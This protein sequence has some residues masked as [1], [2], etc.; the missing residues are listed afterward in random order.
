MEIALQIS[1]INISGQRRIHVEK[2]ILDTNNI[3]GLMCGLVL[4]VHVWEVH[5]F[6]HNVLQAMCTGMSSYM[7]VSDCWICVL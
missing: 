5:T 4:W 6:C 7:A 3:S 2:S 1:T